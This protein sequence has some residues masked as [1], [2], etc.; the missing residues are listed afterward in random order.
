ME[1]SQV[2]FFNIFA[3]GNDYL[4][5]LKEIGGQGCYVPIMIGGY[6]ANNILMI[7]N[8]ENTDR[9]YMVDIFHSILQK[10]SV[11][12]RKLVIYELKNGLY[13]AQ[14]NIQLEDGTEKIYS[15]RPSDG[16]VLAI[17][18]R[19]PIFVSERVLKE[20]QEDPEMLRAIQVLIMG[21]DDGESMGDWGQYNRQRQHALR[22]VSI[23]RDNKIDELNVKLEEAINEENY[24][25][26]A[27]I[28][29][30]ILRLKKS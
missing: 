3:N 28:R 9:P 2:K 18:F 24:E 7:I 21:K 29:D 27:K 22:N 14:L 1:F 4:L 5:F 25:Q 16:I 6:E 11:S 10:S 12:Y 17:K 20:I 26:A 8:G 19:A 23:E 15:V 30:R 13:Y